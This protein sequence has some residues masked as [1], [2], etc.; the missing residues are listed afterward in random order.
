MI[1]L[2][3]EPEFPESSLREVNMTVRDDVQWS[4]LFEHYRGFLIAAGFVIPEG[5]WVADDEE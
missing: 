1:K 2:T 3:Y 4:D 5:S